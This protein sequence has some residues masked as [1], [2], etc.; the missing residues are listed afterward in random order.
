MR[1]G[2]IQGIGGRGPL[3]ELVTGDADAALDDRLRCWAMETEA[4][5][6]ASAAER[7]A[8]ADLL[9]S[10]D[11]G[12]LRTPSLC[13]GWDLRTVAAHLAGAVSPSKRAFLLA[14]V[15][16]AGNMHRANDATAREHARQPV[17]QIVDTLRQHANSRFAPPVVGPRGPLADVLVHG[18]D[19][20]LPLGLPHD[21]STDHVL[22]ALELISR[23][24]PIGFVPRGRLTGLR[25]SADDAD[26]S[27]GSGAQVQGRGIDV[28]MAAC[29]RAAVLPRLSG[30]GVDTLRR[31]LGVCE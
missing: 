8:V 9:E 26:W 18:G 13:T 14:L 6:A 31:R 27:W 1:A 3:L 12:Q 16:S 23:G 4:V 20:R 19:M 30:A 11:E 5:F 25:L 24:R 15:R 29:G 28:L 2:L 10:L 17:A 7:R 21:P 22:G